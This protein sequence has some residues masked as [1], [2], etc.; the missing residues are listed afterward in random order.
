MEKDPLTKPAAV[1]DRKR[2][3]FQ[4]GQP[5]AVQVRREPP[6]PK[7]VL[8]DVSPHNLN[9]VLTGT[10]LGPDERVARINGRTYRQGATVKV[11]AKEGK[12]IEFILTEIE[13]RQVVLEAPGKART[14]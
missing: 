11:A 2:D 6:K 14:S 4:A 10:I 5:S 3:P 1:A 7:P 8:K 13:P 9:L 12:G